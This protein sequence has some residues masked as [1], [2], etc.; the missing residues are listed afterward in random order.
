MT[1]MRAPIVTALWTCCAA[2]ALAAQA[3][4]AIDPCALLSDDQVRAVQGQAPSARVASE[5]PA[6]GF[7]LRQCFLRTP[8]FAR[9]VSVALGEPLTTDAARSGPR[10]SWGEMFHPA[11]AA[12]PRKKGKATPL[13][14]DGVGEEAYWISDPATGVLYVLAG[15]VFLRLSIGGPADLEARARRAKELALFA[16]ARLPADRGQ[17]AESPAPPVP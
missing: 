15:D 14:V 12:A 17:I 11:T 3:A 10:Q 7:R 8:D 6:A 13:R 16:L 9:S 2:F 1:V 4:P 5:Q